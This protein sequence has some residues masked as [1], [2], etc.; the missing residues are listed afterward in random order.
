MVQ[1]INDVKMFRADRALGA[2]DLA[3]LAEVTA[4]LHWTDKPFVWHVND[5]VELFVVSDGQVDMWFKK[6]GVET[7]IRL[8]PSDMFLAE[9]GDEHVAHPVGEAR[10]LIIVRAGSV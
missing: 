2:R 4:R 6:A 10:I 8:G 5:G 9:T 7:C 1:I 3:D